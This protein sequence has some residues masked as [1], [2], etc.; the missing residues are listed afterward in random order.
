MRWPDALE[1][2]QQTM[3]DLNHEIIV[4]DNASKDG[5]AAMVRER[6]PA[7]QVI[8]SGANLWFTGGNNLGMRAAQGDYVWILNPDTTI[9][10]HAAQ[11][12]I[13]YLDA[14]P[15]S[16]RGHVAHDLSG[17]HAPTQLLA[18]GRTIPICCSAIRFWGRCSS[19]GEIAAAGSC[20]TPIGIARRI[21][22]SKSRRTR[23]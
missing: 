3:S 10:P 19:P 5:S 9:H 7:V 4:V 12:M 14:H 2:L 22:P 13:A 21:T 17:W 6:F 8:E 23:T 11:T 1:S 16:G 15:D 20:G 18:S